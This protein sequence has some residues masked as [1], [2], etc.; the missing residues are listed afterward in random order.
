MRKQNRKTVT[1]CRMARALALLALLTL[2][3]P[4]LIARGRAVGQDQAAQLEQ[5]PTPVSVTVE[6]SVTIPN[7]RVVIKGATLMDAPGN[8]P[9]KI[10]IT[11]P[12]KN[13]AVPAV[14]LTAPLENGQFSV[15][16]SDTDVPGE[17]KV[18][19][20]SPG[21]LGH[22]E[23]TFTVVA[24]SAPFGEMQDVAE[25]GQELGALLKEY[26]AVLKTKL[27]SLPA[28]PAK[29]EAAQKIAGAINKMGPLLPPEGPAWTE[30]VEAL[31]GMRRTYGEIGRAIQPLE[32]DLSD[33]MVEA[34]RN[35]S[36]LRSEKARLTS[37]NVRCDQIHIVI[38][39]LKFTAFMLSFAHKPSEAIL[40]WSKENL[41]P[42]LLALV[43]PSK[44][45]RLA[46]DTI[47][48]LWKSLATLTP[49]GRSL[50]VE[51]VKESIH[52]R[53]LKADTHA[54]QLTDALKLTTEAAEFVAA[55]AFEHYCESYAGPVHGKMYAQ[56]FK[57][58]AKW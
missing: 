57:E 3:R 55:R 47:T 40:H 14:T 50:N 1:S 58:G 35:L 52:E 37:E 13:A 16:F 15:A 7:G 32:R 12:D 46:N 6:P 22:A 17:W 45:T 19:A 26:T 43:P 31:P 2:A 24:P 23:T 28:S 48:L 39:G 29:D 20:N 18:R 27:D 21:G 4:T 44:Q 42:K 25:T 34:R 8:P 51:T 10:L 49:A 11:R 30:V 36:G 38:E 54:L 41:P 53:K 9:V 33:W 56:F 5:G